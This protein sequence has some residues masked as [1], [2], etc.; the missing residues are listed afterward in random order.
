M[1]SSVAAVCLSFCLLSSGVVRDVPGQYPSIQAAINAANPGDTVHIHPG[2]YDEA[3]TIKPGI[4]LE[5]EDAAQVTVRRQAAE[6]PVLT[7]TDCNDGIVRG[8]AFEHLNRPAEDNTEAKPAALVDIANSSVEV[9]RCETRNGA[10]SGIRVQGKSACKVLAC[11]SENNARAGIAAVGKET[12]VVVVGCTSIKNGSGLLLQEDAKGIV[13]FNDFSGNLGN[14]VNVYG[15]GASSIY[16]NTCSDNGRC[17]IV[18]YKGARLRALGNRCE[19]NGI[20]GLAAEQEV[21]G[22]FG[23]NVL[24]DNAWNGLWLPPHNQVKCPNNSYVHNG[25]ISQQE[26]LHL[27]WSQEFDDLETIAARLRRDKTLSHEGEWELRDFHDGIVSNCQGL[28]PEFEA[29]FMERIQAWKK[30]YPQSVT[31]AIAEANADLL[32]GW[33]ARGNG[34]GSSVTPEGWAG[35]R[36]YLGKGLDVIKAAEKLPEKDPHLYEVKMEILLGLGMNKPERNLTLSV[37]S[38]WSNVDL[39]M[40]SPLEQAFYQGI[41]LESTYYPLYYQRV[42][43]LLPRWGGS[44][45]EMVAFANRAAAA[46]KTEGPQIYARIA[47]ATYM[48][49]GAE[50]YKTYRFSWP[51]I[52]QGYRDFLVRY[53][54]SNVR[55]NIFC[56]LAC[57]YGDRD[58]AR[59]LFQEIGDNWDSAA[60]ENESHFQNWKEWAL[61]GK[62]NPNGAPIEKAVRGND[63]VEVARLLRAGAKPDALAEDG[64]SL[65]VTAIRAGNYDAA[66]ALVEN[67]A[68]V[69]F[70]PAEGTAPIYAA[71]CNEGDDAMLHYLIEHK[72]N[73]NVTSPSG[74]SPLLQ[75][76]A[77]NKPER[78]KYLLE[79]GANPDDSAHGQRAITHA[80]YR[81]DLES[82]KALVE[83][84]AD[85]NKVDNPNRT[86]L[87]AAVHWKKDDIAAY[88]RERGAKE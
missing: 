81:N 12:K 41:A 50:E 73:P 30:A 47:T 11:K 26:A 71:I 36:S 33:R 48:N 35:L 58:T 63:A 24:E 80:I 21:V 8:L 62:S 13:Q 42:R 72:A 82:V 52:R 53:P 78:V 15:W 74:W 88:L 6:G 75:S 39:T 25:E 84:G 7:I 1:F 28:S 23:Y 49:E 67:G 56:A 40:P 2:T 18:C 55:L 16:G 19:R 77:R 83:K 68:D 10:G 29:Q 59:E 31:C 4:T 86:P 51:R 70:V 61:Q 85:I 34:P 27:F 87:Q 60:W 14:G 43:T 22:T 54:E 69:N 76:I 46:A 44:A 9:Y 17:G 3:L 5:G 38:W 64:Q 32:F 66:L 57:L 65:L 45:Q 79:H 20:S 37:L